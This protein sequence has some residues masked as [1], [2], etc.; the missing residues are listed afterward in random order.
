MNNEERKKFNFP[1]RVWFFTVEEI[2]EMLA[3]DLDKVKRE[4]VYYLGLTPG[5]AKKD[6]LKAANLSPLDATPEWRISEEEF[7][8][9]L[10]V[11]GFTVH[12]TYEIVAR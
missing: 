10:R 8:R 4:Y 2:A 11:K 7:A 3:V 9:W 6:L 1:L 5:V 12:T